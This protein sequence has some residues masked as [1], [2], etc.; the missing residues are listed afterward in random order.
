MGRLG[1]DDRAVQVLDGLK[2]G[3][4]DPDHR[5]DRVGVSLGLDAE[6]AGGGGTESGQQ[7]AGGA[8]A[9]GAGLG[10]ELASRAS[11]RRAARGRSGVA[12]KERRADLGVDVGEVRRGAR[13][14]G[15]QDGPQLV[16]S[17]LR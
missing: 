1:G 8:A 14:V 17:A 11:P 4:Q 9:A 16:A 5:P 12:A 3:P 13:P 7:L 10:Q 2:Q 6:D 15:L